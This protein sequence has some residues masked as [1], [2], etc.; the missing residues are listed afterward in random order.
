L[1]VASNNGGARPHDDSAPPE[2]ANPAATIGGKETGSAAPDSAAPDGAA[3]STAWLIVAA[4]PPPAGEWPVIP[5]YEILERLGQ[6]GMGQVFKARQL[7]L[8]RVVALKVIRPDRR[9]SLEAVRRF[10]REIK[11]GGRLSHPN[12]VAFYDADVASGVH[13]LTMEYVEG[14]DLARLVQRGGPLALAQ[15]CDCVRQAAVG[16]HHAHERG[17]VHRDV[18]PHN[19]LLARDGGVVKILDLGLARLE[20]AGSTAQPSSDL[21]QTGAVMGTP[22][23]M[24]PE[25]ALDSR[26]ADVR[27]DLYSLGCTF[28]YLLTGRTPFEQVSLAEVLLKHQLAEPEA[29][30]EVRRGVPPSLAGVVRRM[31]AKL[32]DLRYQTAAEVAAALEP[33]CRRGGETLPSTTPRTPVE[34]ADKVFEIWG[35]GMGLPGKTPKRPDEQEQGRTEADGTAPA[36]A[37]GDPPGSDAGLCGEQSH[38]GPLHEGAPEGVSDTAREPKGVP[39]GTPDKGSLAEA[40]QGAR[41]RLH[42]RLRMALTGCSLTI[43]I[44]SIALVVVGAAVWIGLSW[45]SRPNDEARKRMPG[46]DSARSPADP[47]EGSTHPNDVKQYLIEG[48]KYLAQGVLEDALKAFKDASLLG[49][50]RQRAHATLGVA[51]VYARQEKWDM[52]KRVLN[53]PRPDGLEGKDDR[54]CWEALQLLADVGAL[55]GPEQLNLL[56]RF[57]ALKYFATALVPNYREERDQV[58]KRADGVVAELANRLEGMPEGET[59]AAVEQILAY[60]PDHEEASAYRDALAAIDAKRKGKSH[61]ALRKIG[62]LLTLKRIPWA[63]QLYALVAD[64]AEDRAYRSEA[65]NLLRRAPRTEVSYLYYVAALDKEELRPTEAADDIVR[66]FPPQGLPPAFEVKAENETR[67]E[68]ATTILSRAASKLREKGNWQEPFGT[69]EDARLAY[70]W[71]SKAVLLTNSQSQQAVSLRARLVLAE[72]Y[73]NEGDRVWEREETRRLIE[74]GGKD[75]MSVLSA[76]LGKD[77]L[78]FFLVSAKAHE[79]ALPEGLGLAAAS[80]AQALRLA[81]EGTEHPRPED[82]YAKV[83]Q[84]ATEL[85]KSLPADVSPEVKKELAHVYAELGQFLRREASSAW[86]KTKVPDPRLAV[87]QAYS[88]AIRLDPQ[89]PR[90]LVARGYAA[91]ELP[92]PKWKDIEK[93]ADEVCIVRHGD[94]LGGLGLRGYVKLRQSR[95]Q[96]DLNERRNLLQEAVN[97]FEQAVPSTGKGYLNGLVAKMNPEDKKELFR[98]LPSRSTAYVERANFTRDPNEQREYLNKAK[99]DAEWV[100]ASDAGSLEKGYAQWAL[101][102]VFEDFAWLLAEKKAE[103]YDRAVKAFDAA[104][105]ELDL[106]VLVMN[107]GRCLAKEAA[108]G[109]EGEQAEKLR[110]EMA[111]KAIISLML[112]QDRLEGTDKAQALYWLGRAYLVRGEYDEAAKSLKEVVQLA[113]NKKLPGQSMYWLTWAETARFQAGER[114]SKGDGPG[115]R[116]LLEEARGQAQ[117]AKADFPLKAARVLGDTYALQA[118]WAKPGEEKTKGLEEALKAYDEPLPKDLSTCRVAEYVPLLVGR[119]ECRL[120]LDGKDLEK[121]R[122]LRASS[123]HAIRLADTVLPRDYVGRAGAYRAA[124]DMFARLA[125]ADAKG[126]L[127]HHREAISMFEKALEL[128]P[129]DPDRWS[130]HRAI[131]NQYMWLGYR[132][133]SL[134]GKEENHVKA[135][136]QLRQ[137]LSLAPEEHKEGIRKELDSLKER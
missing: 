115:A 46:G 82:L 58:S 32:P 26:R 91:A 68:H 23:F 64:L 17:L 56:K 97:A 79:K 38:R 1:S 18:K 8:A 122:E 102:N 114:L 7:P 48:D 92:S 75:K 66:A 54:D 61:D 87:V 60:A 111:Q 103:N 13:F 11:A 44:M 69:P 50:V 88:E 80:Y 133:E 112:V 137:A 76:K 29:V 37:L 120:A 131:G 41:S 135:R 124:G 35:H 24:A 4:P 34:P 134:M 25:Q 86:L 2:P 132:A 98:L 113:E 109:L 65:A 81:R 70:Q 108:F 49:D 95:L 19:L 117:R 126:E 51:R 71:L 110:A 85:G 83:L 121:L 77:A 3:P 42:V 14:T 52:V 104:R 28:Y 6:G 30:E 127:N 20:Q 36:G 119:I 84:P 45:L 57:I 128:A 59:R 93:D 47:G 53:V 118:R 125:T 67:R 130:W 74:E 129:R 99:D 31:M 21:T 40:V 78:P 43:T 15:A 106:P 63:R 73:R 12:I 62:S 136:D 5:G 10:Q 105:L 55:P 90:Y 123:E 107:R 100:L 89:E 9:A 96:V 27:A 16:L 33:F 116:G 101:G 39:E 72:R 94:A 22:A